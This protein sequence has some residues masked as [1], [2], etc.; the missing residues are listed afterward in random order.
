VN[1]TEEDAIPIYMKISEKVLHLRGWAFPMPTVNAIAREM[2]EAR[3]TEEDIDEAVSEQS[4]PA[5]APHRSELHEV[6]GRPHISIPQ[7]LLATEPSPPV[8]GALV[9]LAVF[10]RAVHFPVLAHKATGT[11]ILGTSSFMIHGSSY[12][13]MTLSAISGL[14]TKCRPSL[15]NSHTLETSRMLGGASE[16]ARI[17]SRVTRRNLRLART[18]SP[19]SEDAHALGEM[20]VLFLLRDM[21][22]PSLRGPYVMAFLLSPDDFNGGFQLFSKIDRCEQ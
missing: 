11:A 10:S 21:A 19:F 4:L 15:A 3:I 16:S 5:A 9:L 22:F 20:G 17:R 18:L 13:R 2:R 1:L 14:R 8:G 7:V 12:L 6:G